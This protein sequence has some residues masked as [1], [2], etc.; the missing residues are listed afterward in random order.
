MQWIDVGFT[1]L[2]G[3]SHSMTGLM[4]RTGGMQRPPAEPVQ[5]GTS[6]MLSDKLSDIMLEQP[7]NTAAIIQIII[8]KC[9]G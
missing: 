3:H 4:S 5:A 7:Q 2:P 9:T 8:E 1:V 6:G